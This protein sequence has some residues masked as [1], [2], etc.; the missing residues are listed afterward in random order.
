MSGYFSRGVHYFSVSL[1]HILH[2]L[3]VNPAQQYRIWVRS[4]D[5]NTAPTN[6]PTLRRLRE[7]ITSVLYFFCISDSIPF[8]AT[9]I[10]GILASLYVRLENLGNV[11]VNEYIPRLVAGQGFSDRTL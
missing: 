4:L 1:F 5:A 6:P 8:N 3:Y 10:A 9:R 7:R 2:Y 11:A